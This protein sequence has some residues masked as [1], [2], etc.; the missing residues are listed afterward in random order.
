MN[1][2]RIIERVKGVIMSAYTQSPVELVVCCVFTVVAL[3]S[4]SK[5]ELYDQLAY[6]PFYLAASMVANRVFASRRQW[7][8]IGSVLAAAMLLYPT[9]C[10]DI[11]PI[12]YFMSLIVA[13]MAVLLTRTRLDDNQSTSASIVTALTDGA[14]GIIIGVATLLI[15]MIML[16]S[17]SYLFDIKKNIAE[18]GWQWS[19]FLVGPMTFVSLCNIHNNN[20]LEADKVKFLRGV[21]RY[22]V[23][24]AIII[25]TVILYAY[26][27]KVLLAWSLPLGGVAWLIGAF[28]A[29]SMI[30][31]MAH[32]WA[33]FKPFD[34]FYRLYPWLSIPLLALFWWGVCYRIGAYSF[35]QDRVYLLMG[36]T[37]MTLT[38]VLLAMRNQRTLK[39]MGWIATI[40]IAVFTYV[41]GINAKALGIMAQTHRLE[42]YM[43]QLDVVD[44]QGHFKPYDRE[45]I[46]G[47]DDDVKELQAAYEYL[48][49]ET[50]AMAMKEKYKPV[51]DDAQNILNVKVE[52]GDYVSVSKYESLSLDDFAPINSEGYPYFHG[53]F[54]STRAKEKGWCLVDTTNRVQ[55]THDGKIVLD[56]PI[57][58]TKIGQLL[59][60]KPTEVADE[61][62]KQDVLSYRNDSVMVVAERLYSNKPGEYEVG[63]GYIFTKKN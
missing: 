22:L 46:K 40:T 63:T 39:L 32:T 7:Y 9:L 25:Y 55:V 54:Y 23:T 3:V 13:V 49:N 4:A 33:P 28:Y 12:T 36:G 58:K 51:D 61:Q 27:L 5:S 29:A 57:D 1:V 42:S 43:A 44:E 19:V 26:T 8:V 56:Q 31:Y 45:K 48:R 62:L 18:Y 53:E 10:V 6:F 37:I 24:P 14:L 11:E 50:D 34:W 35:T 47:K 52:N 30:G 59:D 15:I 60:V 17:V 2:S 41:P 20:P 38:T 21:T 16:G